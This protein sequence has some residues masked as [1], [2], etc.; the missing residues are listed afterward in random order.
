MMPET[1]FEGLDTLLGKSCKELRA[2]QRAEREAEGW[3]GKGVASFRWHR[4]CDR[5]ERCPTEQL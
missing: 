3:V 1:D 5:H 2:Q 4:V